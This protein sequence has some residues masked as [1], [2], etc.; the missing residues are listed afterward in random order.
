MLKRKLAATV[1]CA[2]FI[3]SP[4]FSQEFGE[5]NEHELTPEELLELENQAEAEEEQKQIL[6]P[7]LQQN[8]I[9]VE[10]VRPHEMDPQVTNYASD[11]QF[12]N[13]L[14]EGYFFQIKNYQ[15]IK[16]LF[17]NLSPLSHQTN[18][19]GYNFNSIEQEL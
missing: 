6:P 8:F 13:G 9:I 1:L 15:Q 4:F 7:E 19:F 18:F 16:Q 11:S 17:I 12:L 14:F 2:A 3:L 10:S 5:D